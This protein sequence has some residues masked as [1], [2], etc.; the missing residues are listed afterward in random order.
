MHFKTQLHLVL[1]LLF[2]VSLFGGNESDLAFIKS[3]RFYDIVNYKFARMLYMTEYSFVNENFEYSPESDGAKIYPK[4]GQ[5]I[6][7]I[8]CKL[9]GG[10][11][12]E[13]KDMPSPCDSITISD[14]IGKGYYDIA[15]GPRTD[16]PIFLC[17]NFEFVVP[18]NFIEIASKFGNNAD[19]VITKLEESLFRMLQKDR[20]ASKGLHH[21]YVMP[22]NEYSMYLEIYW[23]EKKAIVYTKPIDPK[24][25]LGER[26]FV[27]FK[28]D[29]LKFDENYGMVVSKKEENIHRILTR[30][31]FSN[32]RI[33][34]AVRDG[35]LISLEKDENE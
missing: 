21:F 13:F 33:A 7:A 27:D 10:Y 1:F 26:D 30:F 29:S 28:I 12:V 11:F 6:Y 9:K 2:T 17:N 32:V 24:K 23:V 15:G 3:K 5:K 31:H 20:F 19:G 35:K 14:D 34:N 16:H 8:I 25:D 18:E 4:L 22:F